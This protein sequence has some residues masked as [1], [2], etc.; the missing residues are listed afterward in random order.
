MATKMRGTPVSSIAKTTTTT[1]KKLAV[2]NQKKT[3]CPHLLSNF[4]VIFF[5]LQK[6]DAKESKFTQVSSIATSL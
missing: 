5:T 6:K 2:R 4:K 1:K 3:S